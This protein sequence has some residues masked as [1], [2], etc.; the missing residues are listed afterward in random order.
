MSPNSPK[1]P[2]RQFRIGDDWYEFERA[3][4]VAGTERAALLREF[5]EWYL[6]KPGAKLPKRPERDEWDSPDRDEH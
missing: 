4:E 1:T 3:A 2:A 6:H 5:V